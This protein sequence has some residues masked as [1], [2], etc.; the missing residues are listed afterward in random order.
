MSRPA[1]WTAAAL[2]VGAA[3]CSDI[4]TPIRNDFYEWRLVVPKASGTGDDSLTFHW[5]KSRIPV[6]IWVEDAASLPQNVPNGIAAWRTAYLY[7]EFDATVVSDSGSADVIVR[8]GS[9]PG[10][11]FAR[12]AG[13]AAS[14]R[15]VRTRLNSALAPECAGATDLDISD[16]H[17]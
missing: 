8:A 3:A 13:G 15:F 2:V 17:T 14:D 11:Q 4:A 7:H 6:R 10:I 16:D 9:A 1:R 5:P 12:Q